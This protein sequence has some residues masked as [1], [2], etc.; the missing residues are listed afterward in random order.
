MGNGSG[1]SNQT[2]PT[3]SG[4]TGNSLFGSIAQG[5]LNTAV[6]NNQDPTSGISNL[7]GGISQAW[8][9]SAGSVDSSSLVAGLDFSSYGD[10]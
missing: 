6:G 9:D 2:E 5:F 7:F 4:D 8:M 10:N 1:Q 3:P